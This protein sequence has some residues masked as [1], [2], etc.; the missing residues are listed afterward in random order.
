MRTVRTLAALA[1]SVTFVG[2]CTPAA[3][4]EVATTEASVEAINRERQ[5]L[6]AA[7]RP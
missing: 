5:T 7:L 3:E 6:R 4:Q 2:A 1:I